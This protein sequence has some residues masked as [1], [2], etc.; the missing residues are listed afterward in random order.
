MQVLKADSE[1]DRSSQCAS[2]IVD[3]KQASAM[4]GSVIDSFGGDITRKMLYKHSKP[5]TEMK[6]DDYHVSSPAC[7]DKIVR[8]STKTAFEKLVMSSKKMVAE[9]SSTKKAKQEREFS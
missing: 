7:R 3:A 6:N 5:G 1:I 2:R 9:K 8:K 4:S